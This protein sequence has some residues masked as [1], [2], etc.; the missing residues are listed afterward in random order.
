VKPTARSSVEQEV[1][2]L[3]LRRPSPADSGAAL[4]AVLGHVNWRRLLAVTSSDLYPYL[5][6]RLEPFMEGR[7]APPEW[8]ELLTSRRLTAVDN[9]RLR[10]ELTRVIGALT[11]AG[12]PALALKG[13][14]LAHAAYDDPSL[15]PMT[16]LDLLVPHGERGNAVNVLRK[17]GFDYPQGLPILLREHN[18]RLDPKQ[19]HAP[20]LQ[21]SESR[22]LVE[23]HTE[24][25][26]SEPIFR[27]PAGEFWSR[28]TLAAIGGL[29]I[30]T[31]CP[32]DNLFHI[33]LHQARAHRFEKGLLPLLDIR[34]LLDSYR[35]WNWEGIAARSL[36]EGCATWMYLSLEAARDFTGATVPSSF[37]QG[38][39]EPK[40]LLRLR[41]LVKEQILTARAG[42]L[43][44]PLLP[45][46]LAEHSW[47]RR[48]QLVYIRTRLVGRQELTQQGKSLG[49]LEL[50]QVFCRRLV[51][52]IRARI[53]KYFRAWRT[54][55]L[56]VGA[57][58][59]SARLFRHSNTLFELVEQEGACTQ[60]EALP[61]RG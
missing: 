9:L 58:W 31:L 7:D 2:L 47:R 39:P 48:A 33:C 28:S 53:P 26:C 18:S 60:N 34:V 35:A 19:E 29:R 43:A 15:R 51:A 21:S 44:P 17:L 11:E 50:V 3:A 55:R 27:V 30:R 5:C 24:L 4:S 14:V 37:F 57:I 45:M 59:K 1:L 52:T 54:G 20:P 12:I 49:F 8:Q 56:R 23:V 22:V 61:G 25:E 16:D 46:L 36:R 40:D 6:S 38:L 42:G 32:E 41:S 10:R 13:I